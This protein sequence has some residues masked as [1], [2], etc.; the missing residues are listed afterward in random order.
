MAE[1]SNYNFKNDYRA[2][3]SRR[4]EQLE[5]L[6]VARSSLKVS[7]WKNLAG[8]CR[9]HRRTLFD[10]RREKYAMSAA[11]LTVITR[12][13]PVASPRVKLVHFSR[14]LE[15]AA[16]LGALRRYEDRKSTRLNSSH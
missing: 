12:R 14:H 16:H 5:F 6:E 10:W 13:L 11:A 4:G 1:R 9:V 7:T 15:Q 8:F 2:I 3:F